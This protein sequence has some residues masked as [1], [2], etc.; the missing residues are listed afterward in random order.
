M[1]EPIQKCV[2]CA[3]TPGPKPECRAS[4]ECPFHGIQKLYDDKMKP[5]SGW[6]S[7]IQK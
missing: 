3:N 6:I 5:G 1:T 2:K 4:A 7:V